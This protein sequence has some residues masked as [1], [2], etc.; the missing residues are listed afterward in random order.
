MGHIVAASR[1][2]TPRLRTAV[3]LVLC[4]GAALALG[5][6]GSAQT[7]TGGDAVA[8]PSSPTAKNCGIGR[9]SQRTPSRRVGAAAKQTPPKAGVYRYRTRGRSG[10][11]S[12]ALRA[13]DL[14][15][16]T[17]LIVT[18]SRRF[19]GLVCFRMQK[20]Y[21]SQLAN[22]E[23]YVIRGNEL[24]LVGL[25]IEALGRSQEVRPVPAVLFASGSGSKWSGEFTGTT[26]GSYT[27]TGLG[28]RFF[29]LGAKRLKV[30]GLRSSVSYRGAVAGTQTATTWVSPAQGIIVAEK[31]ALREQLGVSE[32]QLGLRRRLMTLDPGRLAAS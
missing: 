17:G 8:P 20:H 32:V 18:K 30:T 21:T 15:R 28:R 11:P 9:S 19:Q 27:V 25:R 5:A 2:R 16:I 26:S 7:D 4:A 1:R 6:C 10:V 24:Y 14:P 31:V 22:T 13:K 3:I 23:T 12:E 29:R